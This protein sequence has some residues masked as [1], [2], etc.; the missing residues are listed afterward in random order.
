MAMAMVV[1]TKTVIVMMA[2]VML[3]K[4]E[5]TIQ[6][7]TQAIIRMARDPL[8]MVDDD[9]ADYDEQR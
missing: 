2:L 7:A 5:T 8:M 4:L 9:D 1:M 3:L 6:D